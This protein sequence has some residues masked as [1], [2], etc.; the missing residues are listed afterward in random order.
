MANT[1]SRVVLKITH[2]ASALKRHF[3]ISDS[4]ARFDHPVQRIQIFLE[5]GPAHQ[6]PVHDPVQIWTEVDWNGVDQTTGQMDDQ[7]VAQNLQE[8][9]FLVGF[10]EA[11]ADERFPFF[12][13]ANV[14]EQFEGADDFDQVEHFREFEDFDPV[15]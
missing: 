14:L 8:K 12:L 7:E 4:D 9:V 2:S 13:A 10:E 5:H 15:V 11:V 1:R 6:V 3:S